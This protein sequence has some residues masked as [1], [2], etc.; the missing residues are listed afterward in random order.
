MKMRNLKKIVLMGTA[1]LLFN[2]IIMENIKIN[3]KAEVGVPEI[4]FVGIEHSPLIEGDTEAFTITT[5]NANKV[6]YRILLCDTDMNVLE[7]LT[8]GYTSL[9]DAKTPYAVNPSKKF[10]LG[11]YKLR[12]QVRSEGSTQD[13]DSEYIANINCVNSDEENRVYANGNVSMGKNTYKVG[14]KVTVNGIEGIHGVGGDYKYRLNLYNATTDT[15]TKNVTEY[16]DKIEWTPTEAGTYVLDI[17]ANTPQSTTW[18]NYLSDVN[19]PNTYGTYEAWKLK[20]INVVGDASNVN[21]TSSS[22]DKD[23]IRDVSNYGQ[24]IADKEKKQL[25]LVCN[26][27]MRKGVEPTITI[28]DSF[29]NFNSELSTMAYNIANASMKDNTYTYLLYNDKSRQSNTD[30]Q[31]RIQH[32]VDSTGKD[33]IFNYY[34]FTED[35]VSMRNFTLNKDYKDIGQIVIGEQVLNNKEDF[36]NCN[37]Y[38]FKEDNDKI[39]DFILNEYVNHKG[40]DYEKRVDIGNYR[41][42]LSTTAHGTEN[43]DVFIKR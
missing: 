5:K 43:I 25:T 22:F 27:D 29:N 35:I 9:V 38:L 30:S 42:E 40:A 16:G 32:Y 4:T 7:D 39:S 21:N 3:V 19:N 34:L 41:I 20:V 26:E 37:L 8:N 28:D 31:V 13:Y 36:K 11:L 10:E 1:A 6:Q 15:W 2:A 14:E 12:V 18:G 33:C 17:Y 23:N 24:Y